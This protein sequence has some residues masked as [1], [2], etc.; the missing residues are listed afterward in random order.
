[1][2]AAELRNGRIAAALTAFGIAWCAAMIVAGFT[3]PVYSSGETAIG[4][5][6]LSVLP[7]IAAPAGLALATWLA[8][9]AA[10]RSGRTGWI[11]LADA[12]VFVL[13]LFVFVTGFSI[14]L[15]YVPAAVALLAAITVMPRRAGARA[16]RCGRPA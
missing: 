8:L 7:W 2:D 13:W 4:H 3:V 16:A 14:G 12:L 5:E 10:C 1:M 9:H 15:A 6:G 11:V